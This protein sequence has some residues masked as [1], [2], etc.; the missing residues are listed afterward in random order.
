MALQNLI[1]NSAEA[2]RI[3]L[4]HWTKSSICG[5]TISKSDC[6][7]LEGDCVKEDVIKAIDEYLKKH[8]SVYGIYIHFNGHGLV[9]ADPHVAGGM[10]CAHK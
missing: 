7:Y 10:L 1:L 6:I 2:S 8:P 3:F 5:Y 4:E 9:D